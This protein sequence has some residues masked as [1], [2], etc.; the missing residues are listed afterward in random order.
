MQPIDA[1][2]YRTLALRMRL[3][4]SQGS[5]ASDGQL[6]WS[7]RTIYDSTT[8]TARSFAVYGGWQ[9]YLIDIPT[10]G[11]AGG[12]AWSGSIGSLR[13]DPTVVA[14]QYDRDRL[15]PAGLQRC[16]E[17]ANDH[18]ERRRRSV[19]IYL[20]T[21]TSEA[22]GT[23]GLIAN[24]ASTLSR[25]V[26]GGSYQFQP[27]A[28]PAGDYYVAMRRLGHRATRCATRRDSTASREPRPCSSPAPHPKA[29]RMTSRRRSSGTPGT[30]TALAM[31]ISPYN[32]NGLAVGNRTVSTVEGAAL[33][34]QRVLQGT[35]AAGTA[36]PVVVLF[37]ILEARRFP[38]GRSRALPDSDDGPRRRA[39]RE[40]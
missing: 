21:D 14:G 11:V 1:S 19:D 32:V 20:D 37:V 34:S 5:R 9:V 38:P 16:D 28:L 27:G 15:G 40:A 31:S 23:L 22:N 13:L 4:G 17:H 12:T 7:A 18:V 33:G 26:T 30:S 10:L 25:G 8:S 36:D 2:R 3:P 39:D 35:S 24:N 6:L 29:A